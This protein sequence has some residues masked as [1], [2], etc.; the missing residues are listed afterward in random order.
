MAKNEKRDFEK[1]LS[2]LFDTEKFGAEG[3]WKK[4]ENL[5]L[6]HDAGEYTYEICLFDEARQKPNKGGSTFS[7]G[8]IL[9]PPS[10]LHHE[11]LISS[12]QPFL[13]LEPGWTYRDARILLEAVLY[14]WC[15]M[16]ER[17]RTQRCGMYLTLTESWHYACTNQCIPSSDWLVERKMHCY[18]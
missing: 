18:P 17:S 15:Q 12:A 2:E 5:C 10:H 8:F 16:L 1:E 6:E 3:E 11:G 14:Q 4:L 13:A 7:L 9:Y